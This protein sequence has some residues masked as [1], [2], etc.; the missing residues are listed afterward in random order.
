MANQDD[1]GSPRRVSREAVRGRASQPGRRGR[2]GRR[3]AGGVVAAALVAAVLA[4]RWEVGYYAI[5]PG[6]ALNVGQLI[7][8]PRGASYAHRGSVVLT[9][10]QLVQLTALGYLYYR[11][12]R[13]AQIVST[14]D[15]TG[16]SSSSAYAEDGII[17]MATAR[18]AAT[19]VALRE[20]G[21]HPRAV[22]TGV[23]VFALQ[24]DASPASTIPVGDVITAAGSTGAVALHALV[25]AVGATPPGRSILLSFH[26]FGSKRLYHRSVVVDELTASGRPV[27]FTCVP[28]GSRR[29]G[30]IVRREGRVASCLP[31]YP[32][33]LYSDVNLPFPVAINADGIV[34]SSA[35]LSFTLGLI[36]K[37]DRGDL[38]GGLRV[39]ATG[40]MSNDGLVGVIGGVAQKTVAVRAAGATVFLVPPQNAATARANA[41]GKLRVVAVASI[42]QAVAALER[43]GG[44]LVPATFGR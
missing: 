5:T 30:R 40:T 22:P 43:L 15:L 11:F 33:Q 29:G 31:F 9:D 27:T 36:D 6:T 20:L 3:I 19:L 24:P 17:E 44:K 37:L 8:V 32:E 25:A 16:G 35:G 26:R 7:S 41:G 42:G 18:Q 4:G 23:A 14:A 39:A 10:V 38:T 13:N 1:W 12:D 2:I 21:Y 28:L 34:G